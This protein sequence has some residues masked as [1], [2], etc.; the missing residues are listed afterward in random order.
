MVLGI[1][2]TARSLRLANV[3]MMSVALRTFMSAMR[4]DMMLF[5]CFEMSPY[6]L[7]FSGF[8]GLLC[9]CFML[10]FFSDVYTGTCDAF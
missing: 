1:L 5:M 9:F 7:C 8:L 4:V 2:G 3:R 6:D 10:L